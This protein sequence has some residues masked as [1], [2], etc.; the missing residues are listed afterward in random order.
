MS[1]VTEIYLFR[2]H[3]VCPEIFFTLRNNAYPDE[4]SHDG[5]SPVFKGKKH[6]LKN[7]F[8]N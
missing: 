5:I 7:I 8:N 4:M 6:V 3:F 2:L 1:A